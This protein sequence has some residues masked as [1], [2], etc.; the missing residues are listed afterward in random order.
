MVM[1]MKKIL[2]IL[3]SFLLLAACTEAFLEIQPHNNPTDENYYKTKEHALAALTSAYDPLHWSEFYGVY[4]WMFFDGASDDAETEN[5]AFDNLQAFSPANPRVQDLWTIL[6]RGIFRC[7]LVLEK[8]PDISMDDELKQ[9]ILAE[10]FFLRAFYNWH[11]VTTFGDAPL[12]NRVLQANETSQPKVSGNL[13]WKQVEE[14]L[15]IAIPKLPLRSEYDTANLGRATRGAAQTLLAKAY[16]YQE[17]WSD[18]RQLL[19]SV[20]QSNE[21]SLLEPFTYDSSNIYNCWLSLF[22]PVP[23]EGYGGENNAESIFEIQC[24]EYIAGFGGGP[25][26][27]W[28]NAG[29]QRDIF[30]NSEQLGIGYDNL[31]PSENFVN[32]FESGDLR[33]H[34]SVW[35]NGDILDFRPGTRFY[36]KT[37]DS[38][39]DAPQTG[40]NVKKTVYPIWYRP[41][42]ATSPNN[43]RVFRYADALLMYAECLHWTGG[44]PYFWINKVRARAGLPP[45]SLPMDKGQALIH[46]RR[47]E[48]GFEAQRFHDLVRWNSPTIGWV[49]VSDYIPGFQKNKNEL[50][51]IPQDEI[52]ISNGIL[53]Q[54][55]AYNN[56]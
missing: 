41:S 29:T 1:R 55:P 33:K 23:I 19:D 24:N 9:R 20:I 12:V 31:V 14:D 8:V 3:L 5:P 10:A 2:F 48:L 42:D 7:N 40:Y 44:D 51:P 47:C 30:I 6:Y 21:Y 18:A 49:N 54:N 16:L 25:W 4:Y 13:I 53:K 50:I 27:G 46:E 26:L 37:Y 15:L 56:N 35:L 17:R 28:G 52:D 32:E 38:E 39:R 22:S 43:F 34:A 45:S 36:M 11:I